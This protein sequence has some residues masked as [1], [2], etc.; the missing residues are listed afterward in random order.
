MRDY[1]LEKLRD[2]AVLTTGYVG[3]NVL[4]RSQ[5]WDL[6]SYFGRYN[7]CNI[8]FDLTKGSMTSL[9]FKTE[10]A[11]EL[12]FNLLYDGQTA[13]FTVWETITGA[14]S[15]ATAIV[16]ADTDAGVTG[17]LVVRFLTSGRDSKG[18]YDNEAVTGGTTGIAVVNGALN[19][20]TATPSDSSFFQTT[21]SAISGATETLTL[22]E[23][24]IAVSANAKF[25]YELPVKFPYYRISVKCDDGTSSSLVMHAFIGNV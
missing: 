5:K 11:Y 7:Q 21:N 8:L 20:Q 18:F 3:T 15:G 13:N 6:S 9:T 4:G 16:V 19:P 22:G 25:T 2:S 10:A 14:T 17:T 12:L 1:F 23:K 24:V